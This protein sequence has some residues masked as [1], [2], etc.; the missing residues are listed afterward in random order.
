MS[1]NALNFQVLNVLN[2]LN[3]LNDL[4]DLNHPKP[5]PPQPCH[6]PRTRDNISV[7]ILGCSD[8]SRSSTSARTESSH[9]FR[10]SSARRWKRDSQSAV[11]TTTAGRSR[12]STASATF[13]LPSHHAP[14]ATRAPTMRPI[15]N[16]TGPVVCSNVATMATPRYLP[17][18][19]LTVA[20]ASAIEVPT[21]RPIALVNC[22]EI[23]ISVLP[24]V[25]I[26][27]PPSTACG[28]LRT[29]NSV[30]RLFRTSPTR[31]DKVL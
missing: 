31:C 28:S 9:C 10:P 22:W 2:F 21:D 15:K 14:A 26:L 11:R 5:W 3:G 24:P 18:P 30:P 20:M 6:K 8:L 4:N 25:V 7:V 16:P 13:S 19:P 17:S 23:P 1:C 29:M 27:I 12:A